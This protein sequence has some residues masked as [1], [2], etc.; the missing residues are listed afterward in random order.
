MDGERAASSQPVMKTN[1]ASANRLP[2]IS[3]I[4]RLELFNQV[5]RGENELAKRDDDFSMDGVTV[6]QCFNGV[7]IPIF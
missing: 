1:P 4:L 2:M 5:T 6:K 7:D 3:N